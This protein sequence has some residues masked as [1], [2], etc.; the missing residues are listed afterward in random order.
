[1]TLSFPFCILGNRD[2]SR[3]GCLAASPDGLVGDDAVLEIK[4]MFTPRDENIG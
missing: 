4:C 3:S 1:M 2:L